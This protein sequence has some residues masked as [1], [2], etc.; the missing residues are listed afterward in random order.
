MVYEKE[1]HIAL[2]VYPM[3]HII[4]KKGVTAQKSFVENAA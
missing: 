1:F 3:L 2:Q 4:H